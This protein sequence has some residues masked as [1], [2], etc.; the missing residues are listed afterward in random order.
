MRVHGRLRTDGTLHSLHHTPMKKLQR[1]SDKE[2]ALGRAEAYLRDQKKSILSSWN[3]VE[4]TTDKKPRGQTRVHLGTAGCARRAIGTVGSNRAPHSH[5]TAVQGDE[6]RLPC[7]HQNPE[8]WRDAESRA[9]ARKSRKLRHRAAF[10][11]AA[12]TVLI[13]A[14]AA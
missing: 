7:F 13:V 5:A 8:V 1:E 6:F 4:P 9:T 14:C 10:C 11:A 3:L 2:E 12:I